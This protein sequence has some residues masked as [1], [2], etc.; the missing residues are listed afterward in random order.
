MRTIDYYLLDEGETDDRDRMLMFK[1]WC[2]SEGVIMPKIEY[3][4]YFENGIL[5]LK[6]KE[7]I[8][9]REAFIY[10]PYK[11]VIN[12]YKLVE[13]PVLRPILDAHPECFKIYKNAYYD[14]LTLTLGVLYEMTLG[15]K[16]YWYPYLR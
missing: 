5:G 8:N 3:P 14:T 7:D 9:Q 12:Y 4:A 10:V 11:M 6:C 16:S 1:K 15:Q 13:H 2:E